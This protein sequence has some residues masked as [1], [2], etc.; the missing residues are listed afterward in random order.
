MAEWV[1]AIVAIL[2]GIGG[3]SGVLSYFLFYRENKRSKQLDNEH[4]V[5]GEWMALVER[6][7]KE[8]DDI[9]QEYSDFRKEATEALD[10]KDRKIDSLYKEKGEL[11]KRNDKLSSTVA[12]LKVLRCKFIGCGKRQPPIGMRDAEEQESLP[13]AGEQET[14]EQ[15][16]NGNEQ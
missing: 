5:N 15:N 10:K 11:M 3:L 2:G 14:E 13:D 12:A 7:K 8:I 9:K 1:T 16:N 4:K 6:Y